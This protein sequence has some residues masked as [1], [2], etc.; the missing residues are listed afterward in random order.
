[1]S[2]KQCFS[3]FCLI[4]LAPRGFEFRQT[5]GNGCGH[6]PRSLR[7]HPTRRFS[8]RVIPRHGIQTPFSF[9]LFPS[10][11]YFLRWLGLFFLRKAPFPSI[12]SPKE[13]MS[14]WAGNICLFPACYHGMAGEYPV[15]VSQ[16]GWDGSSSANL[17]RKQSGASALRGDSRKYKCITVYVDY[18]EFLG[19]GGSRIE[20]ELWAS[21]RVF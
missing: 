13:E 2:S 3:I 5:D 1:M 18:F 15:R 9:F 16:H 14:L 21:V 6:I 19:S 20:F 4:C 10:S 11:F 12:V 17:G 7:Q 8:C